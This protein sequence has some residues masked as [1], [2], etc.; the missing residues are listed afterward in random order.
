MGQSI[1][2]LVGNTRYN[3]LAPLDCCANDVAQMRELLSATQKFSQILEFVDRPV[4]IVKDELRR[5]A[6]LEGG[7][8][9]VFIYFTGHGLSN[10]EDFYMCFGEFKES[11]PNTT[12]MA[13]TEAFDLV[14]Q[15]EAEISVI[16]IDACE[17]GRNLI[18]SDAAPI[19]RS[20][21]S[22]FTNFVQFSSCTESQYSL[23]GDQLSLFTNEFIKACL[24]KEQGVVYYS[25]VES[26]LRDAFL[27]N[28][29]QT[30]HFIR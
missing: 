14:R 3:E 1:A 20:L 18:K 7:F 30:P 8:E 21:K 29:G 15:F 17:A 4:S 9:E 11:S 24:Q 25:D 19:A 5:L 23:A 13:R 2:V 16:V 10:S 28:S 6:D 22:G 27:N 12:G 26:A